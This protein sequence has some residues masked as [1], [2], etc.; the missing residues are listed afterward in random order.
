MSVSTVPVIAWSV[1]SIS[2]IARSVSSVSIVKAR[3]VVTVVA[4][5][6]TTIFAFLVAW[7]PGRVVFVVRVIRIVLAT[8]V[9]T[10]VIVTT[11]GPSRWWWG[12]RV[13]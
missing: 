11:A 2:V 10:S 12:I 3:P 7:P 13:R 4:H 6:A 9:T 8:T 5:I 1:P